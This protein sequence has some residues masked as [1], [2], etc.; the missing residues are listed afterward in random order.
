MPHIVPNPPWDSYALGTIRI[1]LVYKIK[2]SF[3][4]EIESI[5][6]YFIIL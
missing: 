5:Y 4:T 2:K 6:N 1:V 3:Y